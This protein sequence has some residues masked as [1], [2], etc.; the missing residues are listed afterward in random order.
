MV[1]SGGF[2]L[3]GEETNK[4]MKRR[5]KKTLSIASTSAP[6]IK[7]NRPALAFGDDDLLDGRPNK[8][9]PLLITVVKANVEVRR[10]LV[11]QGSSADIILKDLLDVLKISQDDLMPYRGSDLYGFNRSST[12]PVGHL[13]LMVTFSD[14][15]TEKALYRTVKTSFLVLPCKSVYQG[16]IGRPTLG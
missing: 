15:D 12:T 9:V 3:E 10:I 13:E 16:I 8:Y 1:M 2:T 14:H 11:D 7:S 4:S 6:R 5:W